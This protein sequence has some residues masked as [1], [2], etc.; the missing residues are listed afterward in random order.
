MIDFLISYITPVVLGGIG[1]ILCW[2][3]A[4]WYGSTVTEFVRIRRAAFTLFSR[5]SAEYGEIKDRGFFLAP[6]MP[7]YSINQVIELRDGLTALD[8]EMPGWIQKLVMLAINRGRY[9]L[10]DIAS[11]LNDAALE[12]PNEPVFI[13]NMDRAANMM[14]YRGGVE[15]S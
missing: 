12:Q 13:D 4:T 10:M 7:S 11:E 6:P 3:L 8:S 1:G 15:R 5:V 9:T 2:I 14:G